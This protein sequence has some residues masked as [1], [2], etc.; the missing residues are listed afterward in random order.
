MKKLLLCLVIILSIFSLTSC[1]EESIRTLKIYNW[2]DYIDESLLDEFIEYHAE[3]ANGERIEVIYDTFETNESMYNTLKT[4]K[5]SYDLVC[6]SDY[7][8]QKMI[9]EDMVEKLDLESYNLDEYYKNASPYIIDLFEQNGWDSY[10]VGY[11]WGTLGLIYNP[12][13]LGELIGE[14]E[15]DIKSWNDLNNPAFKGTISLKDSV[16]DTFCVGSLIAFQDE[17]NKTKEQYGSDSKEYNEL[18]QDIVNRVDDESIEIVS[19]ELRKVKENIY[20]LEVD[21]GKGDIVTGKIAVNLAWSG[22]A[23]YSIDLAEEEDIELRYTIPEEGGNVWFDAW[24]MPKGADKELAQEF[25]NFLS[26]SENAARNMEE[27]GYTSIIA[28]DAIYNLIDEWYGKASNEVY[29]EE[30]QEEYNNNPTQENLDALNE[31]KEYA[32]S[33]TYTTMDLTYFFKGTLSDE[34]VTDG[35]VLIDIDDSYIGRQFT[36]QYPD[37][38]SLNRCGVMQDFKEQNEK[39]LQMWINVKANEAPTWLH[40]TLVSGVILVILGY[41]YSKRSYFA[42]KRRF[43]KGS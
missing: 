36:T 23:V 7:M 26:I 25:I 9:R 30:L 28:G 2:V 6:P 12:S 5:T 27:I 8:M 16:R 21:S 22:D 42:R 1:K 43:K 29:V 19:K 38:I 10:A 41:L 24:L 32:E 18:I 3:N 34:Y 40:I 33:A 14:E 17:L 39:V 11:M 15:Y 13:Q 37:E 20:G 4:G 31:A 35:R